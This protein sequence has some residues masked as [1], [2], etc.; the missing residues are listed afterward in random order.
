MSDRIRVAPCDVK[1]KLLGTAEYVVYDP[2]ED[3]VFL[4]GEEIKYSVQAYPLEYGPYLYTW[5][6]DGVQYGITDTAEVTM[7]FGV[8]S[9]PTTMSFVLD[10]TSPAGTYPFTWQTEAQF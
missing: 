8:A 2:P 3:Y 10:V 4:V 9:R 6:K 7:S 1:E 5:E